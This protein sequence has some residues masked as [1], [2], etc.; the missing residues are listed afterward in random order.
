MMLHNYTYDELIVLADNTNNELA[1]TIHQKAYDEGYKQCEIDNEPDDSN[2]DFPEP[3]DQEKYDNIIYLSDP[4]V[5]VKSDD[6]YFIPEFNESNNIYNNDIRITKYDGGWFV[7][8]R[9]SAYG[10]KLKEIGVTGNYKQAQ[11]VA[12]EEAIKLVI[13]GCLNN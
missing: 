12:I 3:S 2:T 10:E 6:C 13:A 9:H 1:L 7:T 8:I 11:K 4:K 5:W